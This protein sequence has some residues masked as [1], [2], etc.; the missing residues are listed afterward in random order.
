LRSREGLISETEFLRVEEILPQ[1]AMELARRRPAR[2]LG[3]LNF[4]S[5]CRSERFLDG[6]QS[7]SRLGGWWIRE[8]AWELET[9]GVEDPSMG[10]EGA[11]GLVGW[12]GFGLQSLQEGRNLT[13][14]ELLQ[15]LE[16]DAPQSEREKGLADLFLLLAVCLL[17][18]EGGLLGTG[19]AVDEVP[20]E[21][22]HG[23]TFDLPRPQGGELSH[24]GEE[25][26]GLTY[27]GCYTVI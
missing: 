23:R 7:L 14:I 2:E 19:S 8:A 9:G 3:P 27:R 18:L 17:G 13:R 22:S 15:R 16:L 26:Q 25:R 20:E 1:F 21:L 24:V 4:P 6:S 11:E 5:P 10:E 12:I